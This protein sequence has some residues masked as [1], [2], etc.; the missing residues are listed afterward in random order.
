MVGSSILPVAYYK[1][2][3]YFLFGKENP[4]EDSH[5]GFSDFGGGIEP[6]ENIIKTAIREGAEETT[7]FLGDEKL[8]KK[9]IKKNGGTYQINHNDR[10]FVNI[11]CMEYDK[12]LPKYYNQN[13]HFLWKKMNKELETIRS[14]IAKY[15][16]DSL[17]KIEEVNIGL[18][19]EMSKFK[20]MLMRVTSSQ[21]NY[22]S[23]II[24]A[25]ISFILLILI[26]FFR[27]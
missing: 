14:N 23:V 17:I 11:F 22:S 9:M 4:M 18:L 21:S 24:A 2:Q 3:L 6:G 7:G 8:L 16:E 13:H 12:C 1:N 10:Y 20:S 27:K 5:R 25:I 19:A 26:L 15:Q